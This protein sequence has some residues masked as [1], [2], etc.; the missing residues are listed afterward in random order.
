M[1]RSFSITEMV[2]AIVI[3]GISFS[4]LPQ[5]IQINVSSIQSA[6]QTQG[7]YHGVS[8]IKIILSKAWDENNV[9]D[10]EEKGIYY[11]LNT[12]EDHRQNLECVNGIR[13]GHYRGKNR[14]KCSNN[15]ASNIGHDNGE[16]DYNDI[17]DFDSSSDT[18]V[19]P[20]DFNSTIKYVDYQEGDSLISFNHQTSSSTTTNIFTPYA[21][22]I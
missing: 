10:L 18:S 6:L 7:F 22:S 20:Y 12:Q 5:I 8:K 1:K 4:V 15:Q 19:S 13:Q 21:N 17:D 9:N 14:R 3:I 2:I 16:N 11:V